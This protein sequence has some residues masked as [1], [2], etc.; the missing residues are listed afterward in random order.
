MSANESTFSQQ[1]ETGKQETGKPPMRALFH[2]TSETG[3]PPA[4][5]LPAIACAIVSKKAENDQLGVIREG[6]V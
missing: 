5:D 3:K 6:C 2:N 1:S 4:Y